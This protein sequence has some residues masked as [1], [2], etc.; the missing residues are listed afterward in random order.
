VV[1]A[2]AEQYL[3]TVFR[4]L[5][6]VHSSQALYAESL[7]LHAQSGL[8]WYDSLI[9]SA[10][11]QAQCEILFSEDFQHGQRFAGLQVRNPFL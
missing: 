1:A 5:L 4:P 6:A 9:V 10:A 2:D 7:Y 3:N 11:I 8:A